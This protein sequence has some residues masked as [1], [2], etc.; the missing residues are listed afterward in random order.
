MGNDLAKLE[1]AVFSLW[2]MLKQPLKPPASTGWFSSSPPANWFD[3]VAEK[4]NFNDNQLLSLIEITGLVKDNEAH[5]K[6][7]TLFNELIPRMMLAVTINEIIDFKYGQQNAILVSTL[8]NVLALVNKPVTLPT[9]EYKFLYEF[10]VLFLQESMGGF[11]AKEKKLL[12]G[13]GYWKR[14]YVDFLEAQM[15]LADN[16]C[17]S[18]ARLGDSPDLNAMVLS[19]KKS[20]IEARLI[21]YEHLSSEE[22][23][24]TTPNKVLAI[25]EKGLVWVELLKEYKQDESPVELQNVDTTPYIAR[26]VK[27]IPLRVGLLDRDTKNK[28]DYAYSSFRLPREAAQ[29]QLALIREFYNQVRAIDHNISMNYLSA[30]ASIVE[31]YVA[32]H[33]ALF[34]SFREDPNYLSHYR[35]DLPSVKALGDKVLG[36]VHETMQFI[37]SVRMRARFEIGDVDEPAV[38]GVDEMVGVDL[39]G[40]PPSLNGGEASSSTG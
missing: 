5:P 13:W 11:S 30:V 21:D 25:L 40:G 4:R 27:L 32:R 33:N 23:L 29:K 31:G 35:S 1:C 8:R 17:G 22:A 24:E 26:L 34:K 15:G 18:L 3:Y 36:R 14:N 19:I 12:E 38:V 10:I 9:N 2:G 16:F 28:I 39:N 37:N 6:Q 7:L 20:L